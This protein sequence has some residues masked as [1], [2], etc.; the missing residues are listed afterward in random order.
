M[1]RYLQALQ[2]EIDLID[3]QI[4]SLQ[5]CIGTDS[6]S[7]DAIMK[8][9]QLLFF[10]HQLKVAS[11]RRDGLRQALRLYELRGSHEASNTSQT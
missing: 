10:D 2:G 6:L 7:G 9:A 1:D 3:T 4:T 11:G 5:R 8:T